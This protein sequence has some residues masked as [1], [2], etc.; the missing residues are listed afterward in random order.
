MSSAT[1]KLRMF[2]VYVWLTLAVFTTFVA[3]MVTYVMH[4]QR[5]HRLDLERHELFVLAAQLRQSSDQLSRLARAYVTTTDPLY[6]QQHQQVLDIRDGRAP[7]PIDYF[8]VD[9]WGD[10]PVGM[11]SRTGP[12]GLLT[13]LQKA[14]F[15]ARELALLAG[16]K[17]ASDQLAQTE[18]S[19]MALVANADPPTPAVRDRAVDMLYGKAYLKAKIGVMRSIEQVQRMEDLRTLVAI[20]RTTRHVQWLRALL[21]TIGALL[22]YLIWGMQRTLRGVLGGTLTKLYAR[23]ERLGHGDFSTEPRSLQEPADNVM[24]WLTETGRRLADMQAEQLHTQAALVDQ[25]QHLATLIATSPVG[26]FETDTKGECSFVNPRWVE[27]TGLSADQAHGDGWIS[28]LHPEDRDEVLARWI[29]A[30][31]AG[32]SLALEYR[33][34]RADGSVTWVLGQTSPI[35]S[36]SGELLGHIGTITDITERKQAEIA[37]QQSQQR[38]LHVQHVARMGF[39]DW[40]LDTNDIWLSSEICLLYGLGDKAVMKTPELIASVVHP[41]DRE[42]A[43]T[44][45]D[46]AI[47]GVQRYD[48]QHR[49]MRPD[50]SVL[51]VHSQAEVS[52]DADGRPRFLL[53]TSMDITERKR[54]DDQ[55]KLAASVFTHAREGIMITDA[56][57]TILDVNDTLCRISGFS[58]DELMGKNP[59]ML[60]HGIEDRA[61]QAEMWQH[62]ADE[63]FWSGEVWNRYK[64]GEPYACLQAVSAIRD[65]DGKVTQYVA[66]LTDITELKRHQQQ[67]E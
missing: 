65:R 56:E 13:L 54:V 36:R 67:L 26:V 62:L 34:R 1:H 25:E 4:E 14:H 52:C 38:L 60:G 29:S 8:Y 58:S 32:S 12:V 46:L 40:N 44:L 41:D 57:G 21:F 43:R 48:F 53:G 64:D 20:Q 50:G 47:R 42:Q 33:Y 18:R 31:S 45:L 49:V 23:I 9:Y 22:I 19:A 10:S 59:R 35:Q 2:P 7:R 51:W 66:L 63:G 27:I 37:L 17:A 55:L 61:F 30:A 5:L 24:G 28:S 16:A 15:S 6:R 39:L 3:V 11:P